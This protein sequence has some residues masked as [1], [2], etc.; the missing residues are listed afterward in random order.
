MAND[1]INLRDLESDFITFEEMFS[2]KFEEAMLEPY[3]DPGEPDFDEEA[4][5]AAFY[6]WLVSEFDQSLYLRS[7]SHSLSFMQ[8]DKIAPEHEDRRARLLRVLEEERDYDSQAS[9]N[10]SDDNTKTDSNKEDQV[11]FFSPPRYE[12]LSLD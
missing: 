8:N 11:N 1:L 6:Q 9:Q 4:Y 3:V 10:T 2:P 12:L 5:W 7:S